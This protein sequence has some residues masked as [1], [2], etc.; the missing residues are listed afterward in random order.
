M[1]HL[2]RWFPSSLSSALLTL[3]ACSAIVDGRIEPAD[4][5]LK[6]CVGVLDPAA[7]VPGDPNAVG[8]YVCVDQEC[9]PGPCLGTAPTGGPFAVGSECEPTDPT[10]PKG[11][12]L[13]TCPDGEDCKQ[14]QLVCQQ[15]T[16]GDGFLDDAERGGSEVCDDGNTVDGDGCNADCQPCQSN[17]ECTVLPE[18]MSAQ[19]V[20]MRCVSSEAT[21]EAETAELDTMSCGFVA[22]ASCCGGFCDP[23]ANGMCE[24]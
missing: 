12:Y 15:S 2:T 23:V 22:T 3:G 8:R 19:C 10:L 24:M 5:L 9:V 4:E 21:C 7:C 20:H 6:T 13:C 1:V 16:C 18:G 14:D 11:R 17:E